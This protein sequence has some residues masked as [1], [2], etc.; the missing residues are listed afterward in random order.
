[1]GKVSPV[2]SL[3]A[4]SIVVVIAGVVLAI[5]LFNNA[6]SDVQVGAAVVF[7]A[8][9]L[10]VVLLLMA[11]WYQGAG[12]ADPKQALALPRAASGPSL[13][14]FWSFC[15]R[16]SGFTCFEPWVRAS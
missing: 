6:S 5:L 11:A 12:L 4:A 10:V 16:S 7:G 3:V 2:V 9:A 15:S 13:R 1:M 8:L 14:Y